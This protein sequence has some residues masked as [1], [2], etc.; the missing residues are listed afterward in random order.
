MSLPWVGF[1][2]WSFC[3]DLFLSNYTAR[4]LYTIVWDTAIGRCASSSRHRRLGSRQRLPQDSLRQPFVKDLR[5]MAL[6]LPSWLTPPSYISVRSGFDGPCAHMVLADS[7][8]TKVN[9][10]V[11][12]S[13]CVAVKRSLPAANHCR[14][15][16]NPGNWTI[17]CR[18]D[19]RSSGFQPV[20]LLPR[21]HGRTTSETNWD[22]MTTP[23]KPRHPGGIAY[24]QVSTKYGKQ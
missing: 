20:F 14:R 19:H 12:R 4:P 13:C 24:Q 18:S 11:R 21:F 23:C 1:G 10:C 15:T 6:S 5:R 16:L 2:I 17:K 9:R 8:Q 7:N 3:P 22:W